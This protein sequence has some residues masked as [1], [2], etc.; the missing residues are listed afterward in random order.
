MSKDIILK[1][2]NISKQYRLGQVGTGTLSHDFN[3]W[4]YKIRGKEDPYLK[5]GETNDRSTKGES[6]YVWALQD[7][8]FEV[9][10]GE[11][12]GIIGKNGAGKS[13]LLKILSKVT[14]P[15]T[16]SIKSRGRIASLLEVGTGFNPELTGRENVYLNGAILG[17]TKK[18]ITSKLEEI[19][20]FS[21]CQRYIDTPVK[22]Y[23]SGMTVRLAF[24]VAAFLEPEILVIDE[25][26]AVGDAEFQKKAIG[27][28]QDISKGEGRTVLFVSHNMAAVKSLCTRGIVLENGKLK[29]DGN[30][31][32]S[33]NLYLNSDKNNF[34]SNFLDEYIRDQNDEY[35]NLK[36]IKVRQ[37]NVSD[38]V[39]YTNET[40]SIHFDYTIVKEV[41]GL[42][43][44]FDLIDLNTETIIFRSFHD[45]L[46]C[47]IQLIGKGQY[48]ITATIPA[49]LL[50]SGSFGIKPAIGIHNKR[51]IIF[52]DNLIIKISVMNIGGLNSAFADSRP[53]VISPELL[54]CNIEN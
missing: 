8:S 15:T 49:N 30:I 32:E 50:T 27:K 1:A 24:A 28:M 6:D 14:A 16:G 35:F 52:D 3:R 26:L 39:F 12:L 20:D 34:D 44:G 36:N 25:V 48:C 5:I 4:W 43:I 2:E 51:W 22:R 41:L 29:F 37:K 38:C 18:E 7:I 23:S 45:D 42:R 9:K 40:I 46:E 13:T 19:I 47:E 31:D 17:M 11:V 33:I 53:G 21:G 10:R 54:W